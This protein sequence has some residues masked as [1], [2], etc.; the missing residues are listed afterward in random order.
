M[1]K[2]FAAWLMVAAAVAVPSA[3]PRDVVQSA[4]ARVIAVL[5]QSDAAPADMAAPAR[6]G[7]DSVRGELRRIAT[8]TFDFEEMARRTLSRHWAQRTSAEQAE[9]VRLFTDLLERAYIGRI[10]AYAGEKVVYIG[11]A[12]DG[13]YATVRSK[14]VRRGRPE[15]GLDYRL[16]L[17]EG[18]WRVYDLMIDGVSFVST[19]RAEFNRVI[20]SSSYEEL[21]ARMKKREIVAERL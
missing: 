8:E 20:Q 5:Q 14:L 2:A 19:Y 10:Q 17:N 21:I 13:Y 1:T 11:S 3:S 16:H 15:V 18:H 9:F 12:L 4:V 7:R 6:I